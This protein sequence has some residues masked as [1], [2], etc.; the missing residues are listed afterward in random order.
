MIPVIAASMLEA[1]RYCVDFDKY[2]VRVV[3]TD[4][5]DRNT[6][7][8]EYALNYLIENHGRYIWNE[9]EQKYIDLAYIQIMV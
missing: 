5:A 2:L 1:F 4:G 7:I 9:P 6:N 8:V 3:K